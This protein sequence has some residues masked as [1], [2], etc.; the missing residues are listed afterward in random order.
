MGLLAQMA[1]QDSPGT[2]PMTKPCSGL[3]FSTIVFG[4]QQTSVMEQLL[5]AL[6]L[7]ALMYPILQSDQHG[8]AEAFVMH[9]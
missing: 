3:M 5:R 1:S 9:S 8:V 7:F 4:Y 2:T 6:D